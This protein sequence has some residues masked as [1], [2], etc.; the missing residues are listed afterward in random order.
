[1]FNMEHRL[2]EDEFYSDESGSS[3]E[4]SDEQSAS[5]GTDEDMEDIV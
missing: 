5:E 1:M 4:D 3:Q 2:S